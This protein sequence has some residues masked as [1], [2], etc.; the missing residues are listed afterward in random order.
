MTAFLRARR[1][2]LPLLAL[3]LFALLAAACARIAKPA[4]WAG[5][6]QVDSTVYASIDRGRMAALD[7]N[8]ET[9]AQCDNATD[10]DGD[11][12]VNEGCPQAGALP[13]T[14]K[15]CLN[16]I[17]DETVNNVKDDDVVN[18]GCPATV[19]RWVFPPDTTEGRRIK[20][21]A[22]YGTP[23][24][25]GGDLYFGAYD[26]KVYALNASDGTPV[27]PFTTGGPIIGG[28][29]PDVRGGQDQATA[30]STLF[31]GSDDGKLY[32]LD[33]KDGRVKATF[34][35]GDSIWT[36]PLV[37]GSVLYVA[38]VNG[39]LFAL[40]SESLKPVWDRP[41]KADAGLVTDPV[42]ADKDTVLVG[43]IDRTLYAV[44]AASGQKKWSFKADNWFWG[45][46]LVADGTVYAPNLDKN[47]YALDLATGKP[48]W[49][50]PFKAQAPLRSSPLLAA[51]V[52]IVVDRT[53]DVYGLDPATGA[54]KWGPQLLNRTVLSDPLA[55]GD[56]VLIVAQGGDLFR[57]DPS[58]GAPAPVEVRRP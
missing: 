30:V 28:I 23:V 24:L 47:V 43:G 33:P 2:L 9:G 27:W 44:G 19:A 34:D 51:G 53:G 29:A 49:P 46:P 58:G 17:S 36:T 48:A 31:V 52:L 15:Q 38:A 1:S 4:G 18:D 5:P 20:P 11:G 55:F 37:A 50:T 7:L 32:A 57:I 16:D 39:K 41:F 13:E 35:A 8:P 56:S 10:D 3:A 26:G 6:L 54:L 40:D 45:R 22:I 21:V 12:W 25:A 14:G 42:L